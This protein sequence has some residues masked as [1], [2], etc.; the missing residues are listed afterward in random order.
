MEPLA[1]ILPGDP[2]EVIDE[3]LLAVG[4]ARVVLDVGRARVAFDRFGRAAF[5]EHQLVEGDDVLSIAIAGA[6]HGS[7]DGSWRV[8]G[9][10]AGGRAAYVAMTMMRRFGAFISVGCGG[11]C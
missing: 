5:V 11:L 3:A 7:L 1:R 8:G 6:G 9:N 10:A 4:H 2:F